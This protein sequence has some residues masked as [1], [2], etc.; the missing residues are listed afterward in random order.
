MQFPHSLVP[1]PLVEEDGVEIT[2]VCSALF[3]SQNQSAAEENIRDTFDVEI[4]R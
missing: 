1:S 3:L 4:E 2:L